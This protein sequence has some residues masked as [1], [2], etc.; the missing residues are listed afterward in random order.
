MWW[1][2]KAGLVALPCTGIFTRQR[3]SPMKCVLI[4][5]REKMQALV[6]R[7]LFQSL[8]GNIVVPPSWN[9]QIKNRYGYALIFSRVKA[10]P[11][12]SLV[13]YGHDKRVEAPTE[14]PLW[15]QHP[16]DGILYRGPPTKSGFPIIPAAKKIN[17]L[18]RK[19]EE[20][21]VTVLDLL[22][23]EKQENSAK[24]AR[25]EMWW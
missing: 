22:V 16:R 19:E 6:D 11:F 14:I 5:K 7:F 12:C 20:D 25:N 21:S 15:K 1:E 3:S 10:P 4:W 24:K 13:I 9:Y 18:Q 23:V 2:E 17:D 8:R